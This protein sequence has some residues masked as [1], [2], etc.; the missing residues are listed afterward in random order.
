[1]QVLFRKKLKKFPFSEGKQRLC[2]GYAA[3]IRFD[4]HKNDIRPDLP[5]AFPGDNKVVPPS[6]KTEMPT[7]T[8]DDNG[9]DAA[10]T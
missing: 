3:F 2:P 9:G 10:V 5:D 6:E 8:R 7:D 4:I 1:M